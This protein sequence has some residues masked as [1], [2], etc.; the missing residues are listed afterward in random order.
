VNRLTG[1]SYT[2]THT[3]SARGS[4]NTGPSYLLDERRSVH[5]WRPPH[6]AGPSWREA[7]EWDAPPHCG[8]VEG[9]EQVLP[10]GAGY[11]GLEQRREASLHESIQY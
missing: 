8:C 1:D 2:F 4:D 10:R 3:H 7:P 9:Q 5:H 11:G 6:F